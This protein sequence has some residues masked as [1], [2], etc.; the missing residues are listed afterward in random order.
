ML[1]CS[2]IDSNRLHKRVRPSVSKH[3]TKSHLIQAKPCRLVDVVLHARRRAVH[4]KY[5]EVARQGLDE[6]ASEHRHTGKQ[7]IAR[8]QRCV[9]I[10]SRLCEALLVYRHALLVVGVL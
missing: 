8:V 5:S 7:K 2:T 4:H 1:Y 6:S 10:F 9:N 3:N